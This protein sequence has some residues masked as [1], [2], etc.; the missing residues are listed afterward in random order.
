MD[1]KEYYEPE[2]KKTNGALSGAVITFVIGCFFMMAS[3]WSFMIYGVMFFVSFILSIIAIAQGSKGGG[4]GMLFANLFIPWIILGI[5]AVIGI[6]T[7]EEAQKEVTQE[8]KIEEQKEKEVATEYLANLEI[9]DIEARYFTTYL[10][11]EEAGVRFSIRNRGDSTIAYIKL[12]FF[13]KDGEGNRIYED[14]FIAVNSGG[15]FGDQKPLKPNYVH[16]MGDRY[17]KVEGMPSI[18][19]EGSFDFE[20]TEIRFE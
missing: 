12:N 6:N 1:Y 11:E 14:D 10:D 3:A 2:N 4:I 20:I 19:K 16:E 7:F 8:R 13:F 9:Y 17:Y 18:W 5:M 15:L